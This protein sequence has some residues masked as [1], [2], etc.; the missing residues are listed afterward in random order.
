[1]ASLGVTTVSGVVTPYLG[2]AATTREVGDAAFAHLQST[3]ICPFRETA[4]SMLTFTRREASFEAL[5]L[6]A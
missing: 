3:T 6:V 5:C 2:G 1:M 4:R